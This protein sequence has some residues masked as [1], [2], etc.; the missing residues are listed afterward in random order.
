MYH[1]WQI[2]NLALFLPVFGVQHTD[3]HYYNYFIYCYDEQNIKDKILDLY[4]NS[5]RFIVRDYERFSRYN[6]TQR[7]SIILNDL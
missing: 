3:I 5:D 4:N 1:D 2:Y 7:L 6:L